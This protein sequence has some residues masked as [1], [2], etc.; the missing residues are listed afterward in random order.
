MAYSLTGGM[1]ARFSASRLPATCGVSPD[2]PGGGGECHLFLCIHCS[3]LDLQSSPALRTP[4]MRPLPQRVDLVSS[5]SRIFATY[6]LANP[7]ATD[8]QA[9]PLDTRQI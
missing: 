1:L 8:N 5:V 3:S 9:R 7:L 6:I 2:V 4:V